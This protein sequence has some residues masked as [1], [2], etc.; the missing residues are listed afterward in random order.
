ML[1]NIRLLYFVSLS[2][3]GVVLF[4]IFQLVFVS[5][6]VM[7]LESFYYV[8]VEGEPSLTNMALADRPYRSDEI[9]GDLIKE[10]SIIIN[11][12]KDTEL[13]R[14][15]DKIRHLFTE[16]GLVEY[17]RQ[18]KRIA[19]KNRENGVIITTFAGGNIKPVLLR[20][21][22]S[23][24]FGAW[25]YYYEGIVTYQGMDKNSYAER[26]VSFLIRMV[27]MDSSDAPLGLAIDSFVVQ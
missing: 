25:I 2:I 12:Y 21:I 26:R 15:E 1:S 7:D 23:G 20:S 24:D 17:M 27:T 8:N 18:F 5:E 4:A 10:S 9:I 19:Y 11:S 3:L 13:D 22:K 6:D 16:S 14:H